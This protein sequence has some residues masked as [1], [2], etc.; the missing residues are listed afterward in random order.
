MRF[1]IFGAGAVGG[2]LGAHLAAAGEEVVFVAR[3][4][5][6]DAIRERGLR[7][8]S[9]NGDLHIHPAQASDDPADIG[10]VDV[11][12]F[13]VKLFDTAATAEACRPL[14]G[15]D[16]TVIGLQNGVEAHDIIGGILGPERV[17]GGTI[18]IAA[19]IAEPGLIR[20]TGTFAKTI[21]GE[22]DGR[23]SE[24]GAAIEAVCK[25]AGLDATFSD[26]VLT[27][28]WMKFVI[29]VALSGVTTATRKP[30][31]LLR[32][33]PDTRA[34]LQNAIDEAVTVGRA[35]GVSLPEDA[36]ARQMAALDGF[37][38]DMV[39]SMLHDLNAGKP[40]ELDYLS[41]AVGRL[42][43]QFGVAT[44]VHDTLY[45]TLKPYKDG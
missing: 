32:A 23:P 38:T 30:L 34:L 21:F 9:P 28:I 1:A 8:E 29:L 22:I 19:V 13:A 43:R 39:A 40:M 31:G 42:G 16:T 14:M 27:D 5:H 26:S 17:M 37:P 6:L 4:A 35:A 36:V 45:A 41:G 12:L 2:Y 10:P 18:Y 24:R 7:I 33:D 15:P 20:Q 3:G 44:P 11:V 25:A